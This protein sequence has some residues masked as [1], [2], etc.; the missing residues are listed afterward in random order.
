MKR[1]R[2]PGWTLGQFLA[3]STLAGCQ[4]QWV[5]P[6]S[7]DLQKKAT[8]MLAEVVTWES[9]MRTAAGTAAADPRNP[10]VQETLEKWHGEIEA[11]S[12]VEL[13]I[14]P[15]ST[16]CDKFLATISGSIPGGLRNVLPSTPAAT[17][18]TTPPISHCETLPGIFTRM[19]QQVT[20]STPSA[21][22]IPFI[23]DQ[24]CKLPWLSDEYFTAL[25]EGRATAGA[26]SPARPTSAAAKAGTPTK[27][28]E[29]TATVRCRSLFQPPSGT[30]HG[31]L[32]EP[33]VV[34]LDAII[35]REGRQA[36]P[37][38]K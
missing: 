22:G 29:A 4:V 26:S 23:L 14:N 15:G 16:V 18:S 25:Q 28:Q 27:D 2:K 38:A 5:S 30:A 9:H 35:Y 6:Y 10:D 33:L 3:I 17:S 34:D 7:A 13:G 20:G 11:M 37:S 21:P 31:N 19:I 36:S 12:E 1:N 8:D 24:Q 32:V